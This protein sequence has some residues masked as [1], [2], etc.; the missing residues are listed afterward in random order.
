MHAKR[1]NLLPVVTTEHTF[2]APATDLR[3]CLWDNLDL[4]SGRRFVSL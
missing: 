4:P 3:S 2:F 1:I